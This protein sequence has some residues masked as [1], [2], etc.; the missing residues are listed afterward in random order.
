MRTVLLLATASLL[1]AA[2]NASLI[3]AAK[4][5]NKDA[6]RSLL[7]KKA[8][9]NAADPDGTTA[10]HWASYRDNLDIADLLIRAGAKVNAVTDLGVSPLWPASENGS[11]TMV[12]RLLEA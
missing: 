3:D 8:D 5:S 6:V 1:L 4:N 10:L 12:R 11:S 7:Q 2:E 9:P